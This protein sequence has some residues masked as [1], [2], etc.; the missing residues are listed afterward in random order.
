MLRLNL[1]TP[2]EIQIILSQRVK[3]LRLINEWTQV[4]LAERAGITLASLKRFSFRAI[5]GIYAIVSRTRN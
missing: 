1:H 2:H 5:N 4:E 3:R